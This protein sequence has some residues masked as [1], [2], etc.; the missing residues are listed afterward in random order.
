M[1]S[2]E[3]KILGHTDIL[4]HW[5]IAYVFLKR[6]LNLLRI[7]TKNLYDF[8]SFLKVTNAYVYFP[9]FHT[10]EHLA[11]AKQISSSTRRDVEF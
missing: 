1:V 3:R 4:M 7:K 5:H 9:Q 8:N 2:L 11:H 6:H 10:Q